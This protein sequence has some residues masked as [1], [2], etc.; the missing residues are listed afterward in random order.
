MRRSR[1]SAVILALAC[2]VICGS[3]LGFTRDSLVWRKCADCHPP[4][5][6]GR[7]AR[8]EEVRTTP[9][10]WTVI[11]DRMR[12]L[13]GMELKAGEMD[14]LLK[15]L[16][17]TQIL[18]PEEQAKV[19]YLSLWHNSQQVEAPA[20]KDDD[21]MFTTCVRCH[22][23]GKIHSYRMN[24]AS[25]R[26]LRDFHLY[27]VPT[28]VFQMREMR[29]V[30]EADAALAQLA[31]K[32]PY[33]N[34]WS[35]PASKLA[36]T[37]K[38]FGYEPGRGSYRGEARITDAGNAEYKLA[39]EIAYADGTAESFAGDGTLYGG[40]ALRTR[41]ANNGYAGRGAYVVAADEI[42]GESHLPAPDFHTSRARWLRSGDAPK[43]A[44]IVP[45][46][47][48]TGEK[49]TL[50][51]EGV[52]LPDAKI[53]EVS[54]A[55]APVK[56][57][58]VRRLGADALELQV[59]SA[60][61]RVANAKVGVK[62][63]D[64]GTVTLAPRIDAIAIT[65]EMG[66]ARLSGGRHYPAEG[67]QFE[68]IAYAKANVGGKAT[69]IALGPVPATFRLAEEKTRR[70]DDDLTWVGAIR[71]NGTYLPVGDYGPNA[72]RNY[73]GEGSGLV[74]VLAQYKRGGQTYRAEA[75]LAVTMPDFIGRIR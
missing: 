10:E 59:V 52:N 9:E 6:D 19:A 38:V 22:T 62:G 26:K 30:A 24:A 68:A 2:A 27:V 73:S 53:A 48:L 8:V 35:A 58:A 44:R 37:W 3:A 15:E 41:T 31:T 61:E 69:R 21:K 28:V 36:G 7:L 11:V 32:L 5:A 17:A 20:G 23:A 40:Y 12:R 57:L 70:D 74:K 51:V 75:L 63:V 18:T 64:A 55:G 72:S 4:G 29:W 46:F 71:P 54:F 47:L 67:V 13:H 65:P 1:N 25:W 49:T 50:V 66:R 34:A 42:V 56:V 14:T 60:A 33:G 39:G 43:V 16:C 45:S